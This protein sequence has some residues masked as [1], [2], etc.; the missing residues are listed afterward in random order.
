M[1]IQ[2]VLTG[3]EHLRSLKWACWSENLSDAQIED[4]FW[5]NAAGLFGVR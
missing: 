5:N 1:A 3:F 4:I 2:P